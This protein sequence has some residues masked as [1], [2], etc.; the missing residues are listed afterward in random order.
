V[1][2]SRDT[3]QNLFDMLAIDRVSWAGNL[4]DPQFLGRIFDLTALPSLDPR[5]SD[6]AGD[7][8]Q[9]RVN[10][11]DWDDDWIYDDPRFNLRGC[12][13]E[14]LLRFLCEMVHPVVRS[15]AVEAQRLVQLF[16]DALREDGYEIVERTRLGTRSIWSARRRSLDGTGPLPGVRHARTTLDAEYVL[17]QITRMEAAVEADP[18]LA[19]GTAKELVETTCKEILELRG[20][21]VEG[22][23][24]LPRLVRLVAEQLD[25]VPRASHPPVEPPTRSSGFLARCRPSPVASLSCATTTAPVMVNLPAPAV[26]PLATRSSQ[27]ELPQHL[28]CSSTRHTPSVRRRPKK[29]PDS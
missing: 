25:L 24:D 13:D 28:L 3:R 12:D 17:Q 15:D 7:I 4:D 9:H 22:H 11:Y 2:I 29:C 19:I 8:W 1:E 27:S 18:R 5:F 16:N 21:P 14:V 23:P 26:S 6:A 10:N 20:H